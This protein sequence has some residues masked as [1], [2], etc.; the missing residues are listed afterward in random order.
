MSCFLVIQSYPLLELSGT[1]RGLHGE[2]HY[3][4]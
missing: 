4:L 1:F 2:N 3:Q